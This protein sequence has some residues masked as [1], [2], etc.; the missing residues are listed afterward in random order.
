METNNK[1]QNTKKGMKAVG[2]RALLAVYI[3]MAVCGMAF[4]YLQG[5]GNENDSTS[6]SV[7]KTNLAAV[8]E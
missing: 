4:T 6:G 3:W 8:I 5:T 2:K 1:T 7:V